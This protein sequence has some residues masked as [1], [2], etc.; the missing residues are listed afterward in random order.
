VSG[1]LKRLVAYKQ[2]AN[3]ITYTDVA[4]LSDAATQK[5]GPTKWESIAYTLSHIWTVDD[6]FRHHLLKQTYPY[7]QR[8]LDARLPVLELQ[9]RQQEMDRWWINYVDQA[10]PEEFEQS[11]EFT[12]V[13]GGAGKMRV[14]D[15]IA[16]VVN[17]ATYHRG[18][19]SSML[20]DHGI[21]PSTNDYPVYLR[22]CGET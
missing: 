17:H 2:W 13:G 6:I 9:G 1:L 10:R 18:L 7:T 15:I 14:D 4:R 11:V 3:T 5:K 8:N 21:S 19:V 20:Y 22:D 16:H 12:F